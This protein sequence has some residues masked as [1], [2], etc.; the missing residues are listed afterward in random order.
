MNYADEM[1][2]DDVIDIESS[3][4]IYPGVQVILMV[5]FQ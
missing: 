2:S 3:M 4:K 5:L 1:A